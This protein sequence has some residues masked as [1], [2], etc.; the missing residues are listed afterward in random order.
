MP[1]LRGYARGCRERLET[2]VRGERATLFDNVA[3]AVVAEP[4]D[5]RWRSLNVAKAMLD[6]CQ[7]DVAHNV[8]TVTAG[9]RGPAHGLAFAA[10]K[11]EGHT[12][13]FA[14][15][16]AKLEAVGAPPLVALQHRDLA[17]MPP[18]DALPRRPPVEQQIMH[19]HRAINTLAFTGRFRPERNKTVQAIVTIDIEIL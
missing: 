8:T 1:P 16:A 19:A 14:V 7:H 5:L 2:N 18:L 3:R 11:R 13:W 15:I 10:I 17:I 12:Q 4:L 9:R 6:G